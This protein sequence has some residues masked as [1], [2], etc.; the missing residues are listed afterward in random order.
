MRKAV[1]GTS[2]TIINFTPFYLA[3]G[4]AFVGTGLMPG[5]VLVVPA[6]LLFIPAG[7][8]VL[9]RKCPGC[10]APIYSMDSLREAGKLRSF[11]LHTFEGCPCCG[12]ALDDIC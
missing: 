10:R 5:L 1:F 8:Y 12:R 11:P 9:S 7:A 2:Y 3:V 4:M 6:L